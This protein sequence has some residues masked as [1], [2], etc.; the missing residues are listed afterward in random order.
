MAHELPSLKDIL[1][2]PPSGSH[3]VLIARKLLILATLLQGV[4]LQPP[5]SLHGLSI[6]HRE[7]MLQAADTAIREVSS[8][9]EL[10][11]SVEG[12]ECIMIEGMYHNN[13][14]NL[15]RAWLAMRRAMTTAQM[16]RLHC[17]P[18]WSS[19]RTLELETRSRLSLPHLWYRLV[20]S[21]RYLSL[22]LG[23]PSGSL[24]DD[25]AAPEA[26]ELCTPIE[27]MERLQS[28]AGGR[29]L[30][31]G[32]VDLHDIAAMHELD[33]LLQDAA[34]LMPAQ[35]WLI[36]DLGQP[37]Q[38]MDK[39]RETI[40]MMNQF[41]HYIILLQLHL[42]YMLSSS[43]DGR[44]EYSKITAVTASRELLSRFVSFRCHSPCTAYCRGIDFLA[45]I[46]STA[47]CLAHIDASRQQHSGRLD[48]AHCHWGGAISSLSHQRLSD[49]GMMERALECLE[50]TAAAGPDILASKIAGILQHLL[51]IEGDAANGSRYHAT[52]VV[53]TPRGEPGCDGH[54][55][56]GGT[57]LQISIPYFGTIEIQRSVVSSSMPSDLALLQLQE[58]QENGHDKV[59]P[60][61]PPGYKIGVESSNSDWQPVPY[62]RGD[63]AGV[64]GTARINSDKPI[65]SNTS[66]SHDMQLLVPGLAVDVEDW[67]LQGVDTTLFNTL[68]QGIGLDVTDYNSWSI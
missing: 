19:V 23:L 13:A 10:V 17:N 41:A 6:A 11:A 31:R 12:V 45:F 1:H 67:E 65:A 21:D 61:G 66:N 24:E 35:W 30:Q 48:G 3:P 37:N 14:G 34:A 26:I 57:S 36:P 64:G 44:F 50:V 29:I 43:L 33:Q 16:L 55:Q 42:P 60:P 27:R 28:V 58:Q 18:E 38:G 47:L 49:R 39:L 25:F 59:L 9:D 32:K 56:D 40:R 46:A 22:M 53:D 5:N 7:I 52:A 15:R 4:P 68:L 2:L 63:Q 54:L 20:Q 8:N 62:D 51:T